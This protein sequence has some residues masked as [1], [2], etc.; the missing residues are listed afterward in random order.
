M[1]DRA[2]EIEEQ[3]EEQAKTANDKAMG[4]LTVSQQKDVSR[5]TQELNRRVMDA[6]D[7][8]ARV[9]DDLMVMVEK[10]VADDPEGDVEKVLDLVSKKVE[11]FQADILAKSQASWIAYCA[12]ESNRKHRNSKG[13]MVILPQ[14]DMFIRSVL[15]A[16]NESNNSVTINEDQ[17]D[18]KDEK[19]VAKADNA[20]IQD[21]ESTSGDSGKKGKKGRKKSS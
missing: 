19:N 1:S 2:K 15:E 17:K 7:R 10:T 9:Y 12:K 5:Y 16:I 13:K 21:D 14:K 11:G 8:M 20:K 18:E 4:A 3:L 6:V